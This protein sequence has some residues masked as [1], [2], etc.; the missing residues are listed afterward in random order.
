MNR[1]FRERLLTSFIEQGLTLDEMSK[2]AELLADVLEEGVLNKQANPGGPMAVSTADQL[3]GLLVSGVGGASNK[4]FSAGVDTATKISPALLAAAIGG[5]L[6]GGYYA[7]NTAAKLTDP[8][9]GKLED[10]KRQEE[11]AELRAQTA[12]LRQQKRIKTRSA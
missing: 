10:I 2:R 4:L 12:R 11:I 8:G 6:V 9:K 3:L 1:E 5:P 7:G